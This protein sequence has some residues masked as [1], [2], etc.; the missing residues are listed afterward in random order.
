MDLINLVSVVGLTIAVLVLGWTVVGA[1]RGT[2]TPAKEQAKE[3][4]LEVPSDRSGTEGAAG[5]HSAVHPV[6]FQ[7]PRRRFRDAFMRG[8]TESAIEI[9]PALERV[10]GPTHSEYLMSAG[11]L[12]AAGERRALAPLLRALDANAVPN[13]PELRFVLASAV[14]NYV[15]TDREREGLDRLKAIL[16]PYVDDGTQPDEFR[17][18][19]A[20]QLAMLYFGAEETDSALRTLKVAVSLGSSEP[21]Y[22]YNLSVVHEHRGEIA[23]A[24][25]AVERCIEENTSDRDHLLHALGLFRQ[26]GN[27]ELVDEVE[28]RLET[29]AGRAG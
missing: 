20:N 4:R 26:V 23:E 5:G 3:E 7:N 25:S 18:Y 14:Q 21:S 27:V 11:T 8:D 16:M 22:Y 19:V 12:A 15:S 28:R 6:G 1:R 24:V 29:A 13:G 2:R 17:A 9:L 10:L